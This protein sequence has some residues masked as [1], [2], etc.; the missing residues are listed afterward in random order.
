MLP[1]DIAVLE[2]RIPGP[3]A[4]W[5]VVAFIGPHRGDVVGPV[6]ANQ[7]VR[8]RYLPV[9]ANDPAAAPGSYDTWASRVKMPGACEQWANA[10]WTA[11]CT[12]ERDACA[13][14]AGSMAQAANDG[15]AKRAL[16]KCADAI[17]KRA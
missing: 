7:E 11:A 10:A 13:A 2:A 3:G 17:R 9:A 15:E 6:K 5:E 4:K 1:T 14:I 8:V 16:W 12:G